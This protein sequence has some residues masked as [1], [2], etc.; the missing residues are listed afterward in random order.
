[1]RIFRDNK[2]LSQDIISLGQE[3]VLNYDF[4]QRSFENH[5]FVSEIIKICFRKV[6]ST[7]NAKRIATKLYSSITEDN[8]FSDLDHVFCLWW[9]FNRL[10]F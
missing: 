5:H 4:T 7:R 6:E 1:M 8:V 3:L 10:S 9:R 2:D